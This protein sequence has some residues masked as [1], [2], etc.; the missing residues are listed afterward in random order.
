MVAVGLRSVFELIAESRTQNPAVCTKAL[1]A[2]LNV[3][4]GQVPEAFRSEPNDLIQSL[5]DL[6]VDLATS[7]D[8]NRASADS[9][10]G[11]GCSALLA[12]CVA[13]GDTGKTM[14]AITALLI[15]HHS[16]AD[17]PIQLPRILTSLQRTVFAVAL[18]HPATPNFLHCGIPKRS[19]IGQFSLDSEVVAADTTYQPSL[20]C[21]GKYL[22]VLVGPTLLKL[23]SGYGG[24]QMGQL[25]AKNENMDK[26][27]GGWIGYSAVSIYGLSS[28]LIYS[29]Y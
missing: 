25:Y 19:L 11:M 22:F 12:L 24:T 21:T 29:N 2:L 4:Q 13:R 14:R 27:K 26:E 18:G 9:W 20:A 3:L 16:Q 10:S 28:I 1:R 7:Q 23:G 8:P 17:Q 6:L 5:F 15:C